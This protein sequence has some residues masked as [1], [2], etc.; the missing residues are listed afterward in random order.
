MATILSLQESRSLTLQDLAREAGVSNNTLTKMVNHKFGPRAE[1]TN[2]S[3]TSKQLQGWAEPI[4]RLCLYLRSTPE[5]AT[6]EPEEI[7]REYGIPLHP[8]VTNAVSRIRHRYMDLGISDPVLDAIAGRETK[9]DSGT[10]PTGIVKAGVL[11]WEPFAKASQHIK[12][13][14]AWHFTLRLL[15]SINPEWQVEPVPIETIDEALEIVLHP[16]RACDIVFGT[17]DTPYRR[18][19]G[20][21]FLHLPGLGVPLAALYVPSD[22][23]EGLT[24][25]DIMRK[26]KPIQPCVIEREAGHL[27]LWGACRYD[28]F[29]Y[30][31]APAARTED[32][33]AEFALKVNIKPDHVFVA[34]RVTCAR[35][36]NTFKDR[37][38]IKGL[39]SLSS[40]LSSEALDELQNEMF[41]VEILPRDPLSG[42]RDAVSTSE[43]VAHR[44]PPDPVPV[45]RLGFSFRA[46]ADR[47]KK[48]LIAARD[49]ELF[50]NGYAITAAEY[51]EILA[52]SEDVMIL[53]L[54]LDLHPALARQF[55]EAVITELG[56]YET[57]TASS[58]VNQCKEMWAPHLLQKKDEKNE[59]AY[60]ITDVGAPQNVYESPPNELK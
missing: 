36:R 24:W 33:A 5:G 27:F 23:V 59:R 21:D 49:D 22:I 52:R 16:S 15:G 9:R 1:G 25:M 40:K 48:L 2:T 19:R 44:P 46:D 37:T 39:G 7:L 32:V 8:V 53:P 56:K 47:W 11:I 28:Q 60:G 45:Y 30:I 6:L 51:A 3:V 54:E 50:R 55:A 57:K 42:Y 4:T 12:D 35:V 58:R 18:S 41:R 31:D 43:S 26:A 10:E 13:S 38:W 14:W 29:R 17:Y 20:L 34:D